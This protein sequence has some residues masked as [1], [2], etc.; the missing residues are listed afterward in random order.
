MPIQTKVERVVR[1]RN[2]DGGYAWLV[3]ISSY[4]GLLLYIGTTYMYGVIYLALLREYQEG[5]SKT[6]LVP[7]LHSLALCC[8]GRLFIC[9]PFRHA[10]ASAAEDI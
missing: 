2:I 3:L 6:S 5:V 4:T 1:K 8:G 9:Y 10:D 7:S